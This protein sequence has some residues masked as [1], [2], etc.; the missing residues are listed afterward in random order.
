VVLPLYMSLADS[1]GISLAL[2]HKVEALEQ[3]GAGAGAAAGPAG[4]SHTPCRPAHAPRPPPARSPRAACPQVERAFVHCDYQ[5]RE[6]P[7]HKVERL[8]LGKPPVVV[9]AAAAEPAGT[10]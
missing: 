6:E 7:E 10:S 1:H 5:R 9:A 3:V 8:L 4:F 2:Q